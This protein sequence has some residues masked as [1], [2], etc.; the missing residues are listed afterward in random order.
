LR[1]EFN[2]RRK[3]Y[4]PADI[5]SIGGVLFYLATGQSPPSPLANGELRKNREIKEE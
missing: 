2:Q 5:Y 4:T 3:W 1:S